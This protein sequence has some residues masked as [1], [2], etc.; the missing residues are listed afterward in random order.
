[1]QII[2]FNTVKRAFTLILRKASRQNAFT[3]IE[4]LIAA[5][6]L[7]VVSS[8]VVGL[9][10]SIVQGTSN[11]NDKTQVSLWAQGGLDLMSKLRDDNVASATGDTPWLAQAA[12]P[13]TTYG[14]YAFTSTDCS[15][16]SLTKLPGGV[17]LSISDAIS[18]GVAEPMQTC[19]S[20]TNL[21]AYRLI[22]VESYGAIDTSNDDNFV[23]CN[24]ANSGGSISDNDGNRSVVNG[25]CQTSS[26]LGE[27]NDTFC[28]LTK[29][30]LNVNKQSQ[31]TPSVIP[32]GN[33]VKVRSVIVWQDRG[34]TGNTYKTF[35]LGTVLTNWKTIGN[36]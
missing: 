15:N 27:A 16:W 17:H 35:D 22:C 23:N 4:V 7:F 25:D 18:G 34:T 21:I 26:N 19:N 28:Q 31:E 3:L 20:G 8:A 36:I 10:N 13:T 9:S 2:K 12:D 30:S 14:W 6:V 24:A 32:S 1:M 33:A 5:G 29:S 11:T